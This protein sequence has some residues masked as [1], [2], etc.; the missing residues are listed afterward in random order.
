MIFITY[1][2]VLSFSNFFSS[3]FIG[4]NMK[5]TKLTKAKKPQKPI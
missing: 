3:L 1:F 5:H 4:S 2:V